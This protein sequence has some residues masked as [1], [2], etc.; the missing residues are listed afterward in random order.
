MDEI[1]TETLMRAETREIPARVADQALRTAEVEVEAVAD[2][3]WALDPRLAVTLARCVATVPR[4][5][6]SAGPAARPTSWRPCAWR[7][8]AAPTPSPS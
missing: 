8:R 1:V 2:G 7:A 5:W 4:R 3:L 6:R